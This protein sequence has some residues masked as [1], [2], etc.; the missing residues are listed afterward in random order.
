MGTQTRPK[1]QIVLSF[2][3][4]VLL[5]LPTIGQSQAQE[6]S[7]Q[8]C[9]SMIYDSQ[10]G[11]CVSNCIKLFNG[12]KNFLNTETCECEPVPE[13]TFSKDGKKLQYD[14]VA[15]ECKEVGSDIPDIPDPP[16]K[17]DSSPT[18]NSTDHSGGGNGNQ[19][20]PDIVC[21]NGRISVVSPGKSECICDE[22]WRTSVNQD[23]FNM[24]WCGEK[25]TPKY[26]STGGS[27]STTDLILFILLVAGLPLLI[28]IIIIWCCVRHRRKK[29]QRE[30]KREDKE[31]AT[32]MESNM[33]KMM[34]MRM[35]GDSG[36]VKSNP[37]P[38]IEHQ[39]SPKHHQQYSMPPT[40]NHQPPTRNRR[41]IPKA[42]HIYAVALYNFEARNHTELSLR[43]GD[44]L[45]NISDLG[46][47]FHAVRLMQLV[48]SSFEWTYTDD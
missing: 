47:G 34:M 15:N 21:L 10:R 43:K 25:D 26:T 40:F 19:T 31:R 46:N 29:R 37:A 17:N 36:T 48:F 14:P 13:C 20:S 11:K 35:M 4:A 32:N 30:E 7:D 45:D 41:S 22:G 38:T 27:T 5:L 18:D 6:G 8:C 42:H 12:K 1:V 3:L 16:P 33:F 28:L 39:P 2:T 44:V 9:K 24:T 23:P